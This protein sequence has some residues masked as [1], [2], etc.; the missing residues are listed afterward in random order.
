MRRMCVPIPNHARETEGMATWR[1][2]SIEGFGDGLVANGAFFYGC[3]DLYGSDMDCEC[4][5][6]FAN[7]GGVRT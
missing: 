2:A 7:T 5:V 4:W 3:H 1:G 6:N